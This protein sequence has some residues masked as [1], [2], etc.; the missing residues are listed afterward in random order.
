MQ[1]QNQNNLT[2]QTAFSRTSEDQI[3]QNPSQNEKETCASDYQSSEA[4]NLLMEEK[5]V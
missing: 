3:S 1:N 5:R 2:A 4:L